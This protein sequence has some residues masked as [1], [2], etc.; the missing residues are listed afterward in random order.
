MR[1]K[2]NSVKVAGLK[3]EALLAAFIADQVYDD[4]G[5]DFVITSVCDGKHSDTSLHYVGYAFDCRIYQSIDND[6][7][8]K[9]IKRRLNIDYDVILE[10]NHIHVEFQPRYR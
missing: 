2:D 6:K 7:I 3:T 4:F 10:G 5:L 9:E 8:V 1:L